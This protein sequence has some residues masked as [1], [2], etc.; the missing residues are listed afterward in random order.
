M[1]GCDRA[2]LAF[3]GARN[4][5]LEGE[6]WEEFLGGGGSICDALIVVVVVV[7]RLFARSVRHPLPLFCRDDSAL[8]KD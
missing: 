5:G 8:M 4:E 6:R 7:V 3:V 1:L 2:R